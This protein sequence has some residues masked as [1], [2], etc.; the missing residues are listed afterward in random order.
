MKDSR[1][2]AARR[3]SGK[4]QAQVAREVGISELAYQ[5]YE[6][7]KREPRV[8]TAIRIADALDVADVRELFAAAPEEPLQMDDT[9]KDAEGQEGRQPG[10]ERF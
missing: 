8:R 7:G 4:T 9:T 6:W 1:L 2:Q 10:R 3:A 5:F